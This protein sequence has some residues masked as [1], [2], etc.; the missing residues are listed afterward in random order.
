MYTCMS[1]IVSDTSTNTF[2]DLICAILYTASNEKFKGLHIPVTD[3]IIISWYKT[4][5]FCK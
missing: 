2:L 4:A 1:H 5:L 3:F